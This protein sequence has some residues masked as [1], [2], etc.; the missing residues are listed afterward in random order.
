M[1][2]APTSK[3]PLA[4]ADGPCFQVAAAFGAFRL[5]VLGDAPRS[6]K[7]ARYDKNT[8]RRYWSC[9]INHLREVIRNGTGIVRPKPCLIL[10]GIKYGAYFAVMTSACKGGGAGA[11]APIPNSAPKLPMWLA[12][13]SIASKC[14]KCYRSMRSRPFRL[15]SG[16]RAICVCPTGKPSTV[17]VTDTN[18]TAPP[19]SSPR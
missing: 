5:A 19:R 2:A 10:T 17:L 1:R 12:C 3:S 13:T 9:S 15:W 14:A 11:S 16:H 7:P 6:G 4:Y 8:K 18:G